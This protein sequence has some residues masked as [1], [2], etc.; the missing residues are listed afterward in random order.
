MAL[1]LHIETATPTCSVN[2]SE[3]SKV[4][5]MRESHVDRSHAELLS[6]FI[7]ELF[8]ELGIKPE[9][10]DAINVS[11][12]PGSY[13]G[14]R[15]GVSTA[16]GLAYGLKIPLISLNTLEAMAWGMLHSAKIG[17]SPVENDFLLCPMIDARR[18]EVYTALFD[19]RMKIV[20]ET[21]AEIID[22]ESFLK[23]LDKGKIIFF[24]DGASKC[25][26]EIQHKNAVF[27]DEFYNSSAYMT[28]L[29]Y[30]SFKNEVFE[31]VA[32]FDPFYLKDFIPTV[33]KNKVI[34]S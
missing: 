19:Q 5:G 23:Y 29:G 34:G 12:G 4:L 31:D 20:K 6:V 8:N 17:K 16:K 9:N 7:H 22:N 21:S 11:K 3:N 10:L 18:M 28:T 13:T 30:E 26:T 33:P 14:L 27:I 15:I 24:G 32:Y 1:L 2:I 25:I